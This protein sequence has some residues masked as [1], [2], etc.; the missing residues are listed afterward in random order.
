MV[1][2]YDSLTEKYQMIFPF[3]AREALDDLFGTG[4]N[5]L[6]KEVLRDMCSKLGLT[7][8]LKQ[9]AHTFLVVN[10]VLSD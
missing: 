2:F 6:Q 8:D 5:V 7:C 3:I 1:L 4:G 10:P 9:R